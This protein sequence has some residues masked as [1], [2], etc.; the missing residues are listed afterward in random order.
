MILSLRIGLAGR[1]ENHIFCYVEPPNLSLYTQTEINGRE[2]CVVNPH[3]PLL[4]F[5][6]TESG[7][8]SSSI[9]SK[10]E[11][12]LLTIVRGMIVTWA[13]EIQQITRG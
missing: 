4:V 1:V 8:D 12:Q 5:Y 6:K 2:P 9:S 7:K 13:T 3:A 11:L 10:S